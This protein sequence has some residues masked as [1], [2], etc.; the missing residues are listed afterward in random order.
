MIR[1]T[2]VIVRLPVASMALMNN[3]CACGQMDLEKSGSKA[4]TKIENSGG[5]V[6]NGHFSKLSLTRIYSALQQIPNG[7]VQ[8]GV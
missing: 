7:K 8:L 3:T 2:A 4:T 6:S 1:D 5:R